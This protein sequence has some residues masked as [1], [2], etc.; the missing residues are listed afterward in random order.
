MVKAE[1]VVQA[2]SGVGPLGRRA[3]WSVLCFVYVLL[4]VWG[5]VYFVLHSLMFQIS[6]FADFDFLFRQNLHCPQLCN[7]NPSYPYPQMAV[8]DSYKRLLMCSTW[9]HYSPLVGFSS[10]AAHSDSTSMSAQVSVQDENVPPQP[11][12]PQSHVP[13]VMTGA[14]HWAP[15][16][17]P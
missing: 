2:H 14:L 3:C 1:M 4:Y 9:S 16:K 10:L 13:K 12:M 17:K 8:G 11:I 7:W 5:N 6:F 15:K